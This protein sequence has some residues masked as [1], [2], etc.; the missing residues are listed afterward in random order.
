MRIQQILLNLINNAIKF[1]Y[2]GDT[3]KVVLETKPIDSEFVNVTIAVIDYGIGITEDDMK[4]L[5]KPYFIST[6]ERSKALNASSHGIGLSFCQQ[7]AIGLKG[8]LT[9]K[10]SAGCGAEFV[11]SFPAKILP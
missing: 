4:K 9:V 7:I 11:F 1:S 2:E 5:F 8:S 10:S 6:D 3:I